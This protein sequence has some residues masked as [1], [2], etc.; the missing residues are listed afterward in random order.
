MPF[1]PCWTGSWAPW[2]G[3]AA[4]EAAS[5][6]T[7]A[8]QIKTYHTAAASDEPALIPGQQAVIFVD[9]V[10]VGVYG[11]VHPEVLAEYEVPYPRQ[12]WSL[13]S[14][15]S[16]R[17]SPDYTYS[18]TYVNG[19]SVYMCGNFLRCPCLEVVSFREA[20]GLRIRCVFFIVTV[21]LAC[22]VAVLISCF[23]QCVWMFFLLCARSLASIT[24]L[25]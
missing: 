16:S 24:R 9:K 2:C 25:C 3:Y 12:C 11:I 14:S 15:L 5:S 13:T 1:R 19:W 10:Q 21:K 23:N 6:S 22:V 4:E 17:S 20:K 18:S 8:P 7:T